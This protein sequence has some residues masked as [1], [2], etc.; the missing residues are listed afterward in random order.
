ML[1]FILLF[2]FIYSQAQVHFVPA[3]SGNGNDHMNISVA[4]ATLSGIN[5]EVGDEIAAFD[6]SIC[7][8]I[9]ILKKSISF[10]D[11]LSYGAIAASRADAGLSNGYT[12]G[13]TITYKFWDSSASKEYSGI[14][15]EYLDPQTG[16][17][18]SAPTYTIGGLAIVKLSFLAVNQTPVANAGADQIVNEGV[19][20]TLDGTG[21]ADP[22]G[23]TLTYL[24]AAPAGVTLS[25]ATTSKPTFTAPEVTTDTDYTLSLVV[26]DGFVNSTS[27]NVKITVKQVNKAPT[28][29]A[30]ADQIVNEGVLV[31]LD[32]TGSND[33]DGN[34]LTYLWTAPAGVT[35]SSAT[36]S[37]PTFTAPEV[38]ADTDYTF[39]IVVNDGSVNSTSDNV[40]IT[41]KQVNKAPTANAGADQIVN[42][43]VL[44]TLD[45]TGSTDTDGDILTYSWTAPAGITLSSA[46]ASKPAFTAPEVTADT[47]YTF[48]LVVNDGSV[49]SNSVNVK[50]TVKN[51]PNVGSFEK[52]SK[53]KLFPNPT[54]GIIS[55]I[56][57]PDLNYS[58][59]SLL[60]YA[61][62]ELIKMKITDEL[63]LNL[64]EFADGFYYVR[65]K[66]G[67]NVTTTKILLDKN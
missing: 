11:F 62:Q 31:N 51:N 49:N 21:S 40:K 3:F 53:F 56:T 1:S 32:G 33:P 35:L 10:S 17:T 4:T 63:I 42:E 41:V 55:L 47:D 34:T 58:E 20:V 13:N 9:V 67:N 27:D 59:I 52:E 24:W 18:I 61:G 6:G 65:L 39:S 22:D 60:N 25:S 36:A 46:T 44:V 48:S 12:P 28:A 50:I 16:K 19:L 5:L 37:K 23:N 14:V 66:K 54:S 38:T 15:A 57:G 43:G 8:G 2:P 64:S 26:N 45:G 30:G 29:N 7:C